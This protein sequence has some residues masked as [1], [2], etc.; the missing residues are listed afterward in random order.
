MCPK[1]IVT[2]SILNTYTAVTTLIGTE[3][4]I[5]FKIVETNF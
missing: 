4:V 1:V 3:V 2:F 5:L